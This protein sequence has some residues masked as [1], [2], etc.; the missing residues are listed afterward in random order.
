MISER[1]LLQSIAN[2][3]PDECRQIGQ[4]FLSFVDA[5]RDAVWEANFRRR[6]AALPVQA[7]DLATLIAERRRYVA[8]YGGALEAWRHGWHPI[9]MRRQLEAMG[10]KGAPGGEPDA[11]DRAAMASYR[12]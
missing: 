5:P 9:Q 10:Y 4:L 1:D 11:A 2:S 12:L 3:T 7:S 8:E 6:L